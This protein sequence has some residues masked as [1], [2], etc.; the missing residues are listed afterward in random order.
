MG[1][2]DEL[3]RITLR[4]SHVKT[5]ERSRVNIERRHARLAE[6]A[7][8]VRSWSVTFDFADFR[9]KTLRKDLVYFI[10]FIQ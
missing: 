3:R 7:R 5:L 1:L 10:F 9:D 8:Q 2:R 4:S 6:Q